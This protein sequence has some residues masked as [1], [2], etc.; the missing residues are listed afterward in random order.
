M[1][2]RRRRIGLSLDLAEARRLFSVS[3]DDK[4]RMEDKNE[5]DTIINN[6]ECKRLS[7]GT[8]VHYMKRLVQMS[9]HRENIADI[10]CTYDGFWLMYEPMYCTADNGV[11]TH[12][13]WTLLR[14]MSTFEETRNKLL[15]NNIVWKIVYFMKDE[16]I[17][18]DHI[19]QTLWCEIL[20]NLS[21]GY[22]YC[23]YI[24]SKG[25]IQAL[26]HI[27]P[28]YPDAVALQKVGCLLLH[29]LCHRL[30]DDSDSQIL[31]ID[32]IR[33]IVATN[34]IAIVEAAGFTFVTPIRFAA[35]DNTRA[36][37]YNLLSLLRYR[38]DA[39][40]IAGIWR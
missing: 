8:L 9:K 6:I 16:S 2:P 4:E 13:V 38:K 28:K 15:N 40:E 19:L 7:K 3:V 18:V 22:R 5:I 17:F 12:T 34:G 25:G 35:D 32:R 37:H 21:A 29:N 14:N 27:M 1:H 36:T 39:D 33:E 30:A 20:Q 23:S 11:L 10:I 24:S 26:L 31:D